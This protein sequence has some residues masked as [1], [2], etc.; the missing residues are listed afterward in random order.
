MCVC[1]CVYIYRERDYKLV[2]NV[3]KDTNVMYFYFNFVFKKIKIILIQPGKGPRKLK[4]GLF[5][6]LKEV[7][8][9]KN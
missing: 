9:C 8:E 4:T 3:Y 1:V 2:S 6:I 5:L 7:V